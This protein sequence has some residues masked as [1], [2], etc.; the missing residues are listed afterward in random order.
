MEPLGLAAIVGLLFVKESGLPVPVPGDLLVLGLGVGAAQGRFDPL[1]ALAAAIAATIV[2]GCV[3]FALLR[4]PGRR[5]L[6]AVL[7][8]V[9]LSEARIERQAE[10]FRRRGASAVAVARMTPG[11]RIVAIAGAAVAAIP[12]ARFA[13]GLAGGNTVFTGGHFVLGLAFGAAAPS[14]AA[15]VAPVVLGLV[16]LAAIGFGGWRVIARRGARGSAPA[17]DEAASDWSDACCPACL[18]LAWAAPRPSDAV[19]R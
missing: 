1:V 8:R 17:T 12:F 14:V 2:G 19:T 11:V 13:A 18:A 7:R 4:G 3:Q 9:G 10:R 6:L 5:V 16:V 15:G